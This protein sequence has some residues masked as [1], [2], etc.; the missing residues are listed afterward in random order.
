MLT[1]A[2]KNSPLL[3]FSKLI[4][5]NLNT[6]SVWHMHFIEEF[7]FYI[8]KRQSSIIKKDNY[9]M[10][11][12]FISFNLK[13]SPHLSLGQFSIWWWQWWSRSDAVS[14]EYKTEG[15]N[16]NHQPKVLWQGS[17]WAAGLLWRHPRRS[18]VQA[19]SLIYS[20]NINMKTRE[21]QS[22]Y[23]AQSAPHQQPLPMEKQS[24]AGFGIMEST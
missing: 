24:S 13:Q 19:V 7:E 4:V 3:F 17:I 15:L 18:T 21:Q 5:H 14:A 6:K 23:G 22:F 20:S 1:A 16:L 12:C 10:H 8:L 9:T 11:Y 2:F